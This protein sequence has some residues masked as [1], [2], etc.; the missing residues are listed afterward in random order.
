MQTSRFD[1]QNVSILTF[2]E[3]AASSEIKGIEADFEYIAT[4]NLSLYG[5]ISLNDTEL[6]E[7]N[8]Q[9]I[10][11]A[12]IGSELPVTPK[13]QGNLRARYDWTYGEFDL[14]WQVAMQ[15]ASKSYSSI[16]AEERFE[17]DS[18]SLFN[19]SIGAQKDGW[20]VRLY[21][22]NITD[23]RAT[24]FINNQDDIQRIS[25]NRPRTIG[26]SVNYSYY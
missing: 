6:T 15:F 16:V 4:D 24:L 5:A 12:P 19:A 1:P 3:N 26:M 21:V 7:L 14:D 25:T 2:I 8:A 10:E 13:T 9:V 17:Q 20:R 18:Y 22:D 23:E 11:M